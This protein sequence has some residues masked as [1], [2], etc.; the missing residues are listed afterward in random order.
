MKHLKLTLAATL[1][2]TLLAGCSGDSE[3]KLIASAQSYLAQRDTKA[4]VIQLK[5]ALQKN[6]DSPTARLLLGRALLDSGDARG[7]LEELRKAQ[8]LGSPEDETVPATARALLAVGE[9]QKIVEQFGTKT[10][11]TPAAN[12]DLLSSL[13]A[14]HVLLRDDAKAT[15]YA[16]RALQAQPGFPAAMVLQAQ[17]KATQGDI[18]GALAQVEQVLK[19]DPAHHGAGTLKGVLLWQGKRDPDAAIA[20]YR[21]VLAAHPTSVSARSAL[22]GL[23]RDKGDRDGATAELTELKKTAPNHP[24]TQFLEARA[25][26]EARDYRRAQDLMASVLKAAPDNPAALELAGAAAFQGRAFQQAEAHL[27]R[28]LQLSPGRLA[29]RRM[30]AQAQLRGGQPAR[31]LETLAPALAQPTVD[32][33]TLALAGEAHLQAGDAAKADEAFRRAA[34]AAPDDKQVRT[35]VAIAMAARGNMSE[36]LP[37]L[38]SLA[39]SD[40]S[41]RADLALVSARMAQ[42]DFAG[43]TKAIEALKK[44]MP[45]APLPDFLRG[46]VLVA[47]GN[48]AGAAG[49]FEAALAKDPTHLPSAGALAA[50]DMGANKPE[51]ARQRFAAVLKANPASYAAH[52][53][54]ADLAQ[55][56]GGSADD[57]KRHLADAVQASPGEPQPRVQ[58]VN[59]LLRQNDPKGAV[60][61]A[62]D[63]IAAQPDQPDLLDALGRAQMAAGETQQALLTFRKLA[64]S[65]PQNGQFTVRLAEAQFAAKDRDGARTT[66]KRALQVDPRLFAAQR[67]LATLAM[68]E[69]KPDEALA[70]AREWQ[71][72]HPQDAA[73]FALEGEVQVA[74]KD[75]PAA[76]SALRAALERQ[77]TTELAVALHAAL[78]N[79]GQKAEAERWA[80][81]WQRQRP[82]DSGFRFHLGDTALAR[83]DLP[84][85]EGHYRAVMEQQPGNAVAMNNVAW[86]LAKQG[87]P[88]AVALA[89]QAAKLRPE[90]ATILDTL[91]FALAADKQLPRAIE[92]QK[93]A[94]ARA[95]K[96][97][98]LRLNLAKLYL[99]AGEKAQA[100]GELDTLA[101]LGDGF[102]GQAE[103]AQLQKQA[104]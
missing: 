43:A 101:K 103:V 54:L 69:Q 55:R 83:G 15:D 7:A 66:L 49:A 70:L 48:T 61:A 40:S 17:A 25:A 95:P 12:A 18:D 93:Q 8:A 79:G 19:T 64:A 24:E 2:A 88:G 51:Q 11:A 13:A 34:K 53:A 81:D 4:A 33:S 30:L 99:Q 41:P 85:A 67:G 74:R 62:Q 90:A 97:A 35:T 57:V 32:G 77:K 100:R 71:K 72:G 9:A 58:L 10:L 20:A 59:H 42:R 75:W 102:R 39:A 22:V 98:S 29:A 46:R 91:A 36:A 80:A 78:L 38:E 21:Q 44:K 5:N 14:A 104:Q 47:Q 87:R 76:V 60:A 86:I 6:P 1:V 89:E 84:A 26:F 16:Q 63:G 96:D 73:G 68:A 31:A 23:L 92:V 50:L 37:Q 56:S 82:K 28:T 3:E 94:L 27:A 65:Q 52:L 45:D